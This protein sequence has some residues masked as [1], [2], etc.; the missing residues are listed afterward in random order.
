MAGLDGGSQA[1]LIR[2]YQKGGLGVGGWLLVFTLL[3]ELF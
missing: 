1:D 2:K 3:V